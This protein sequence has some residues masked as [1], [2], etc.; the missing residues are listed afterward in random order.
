MG[1]SLL[2]YRVTITAVTG[3]ATPENASAETTFQIVGPRLKEVLLS[4]ESVLT[5]RVP[6][7]SFP[8]AHLS[9]MIFPSITSSFLGHTVGPHYSESHNRTS[10]S[11][12][13]YTELSEVSV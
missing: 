10:Q 7:Y 8:A 11:Q 3:K 12:Y 2:K 1:A 6:Y 5:S 4:R 9:S 13:G